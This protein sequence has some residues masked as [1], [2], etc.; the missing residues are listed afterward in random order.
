VSGASVSLLTLIRRRALTLERTLS[1]FVNQAYGLTPAEIDLIW[2]TAPPAC[3]S[4]R[5]PASD[6]RSLISGARRLRSPTH[7]S[8][9]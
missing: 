4:R 1:D 6:P 2:Q 9:L 5:L 8:S 3:P 7:N